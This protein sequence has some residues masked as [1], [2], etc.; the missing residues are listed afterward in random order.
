MLFLNVSDVKRKTIMKKKMYNVKFYVF[1][2][3]CTVWHRFILCMYM[4]V[5]ELSFQIEEN[6]EAFAANPLRTY[7]FHIL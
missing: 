7:K 6:Q 4:R 3:I 1:Q 2:I 5:A